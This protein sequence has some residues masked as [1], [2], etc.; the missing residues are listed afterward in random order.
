LSRSAPV[1]CEPVPSAATSPCRRCQRAA[2]S[3]HRPLAQP[4]YQL[5]LAWAR[6]RGR[7]EFGGGRIIIPSDRIPSGWTHSPR[8]R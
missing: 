6:R 8:P 3:A 1:M 7:T 5:R 2:R 4:R